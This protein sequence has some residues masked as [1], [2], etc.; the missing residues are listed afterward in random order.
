MSERP[1]NLVCPVKYDWAVNSI[2]LG[3]AY[4]SLVDAGTL[5]KGAKLTKED[6]ALVKEAYVS[7][8][9]L[10]VPEQKEVLA[11]KRPRST[12]NLDKFNK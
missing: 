3:Q 6:E 7:R 12:S 9:G 2:K 10:L 8:K 5:K 4:S 11:Q 1:L